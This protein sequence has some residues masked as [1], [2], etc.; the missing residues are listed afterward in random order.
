MFSF[1]CF[2]NY[3]IQQMCDIICLQKKTQST[4]FFCLDP[5]QLIFYLDISFSTLL[6]FIYQYL[7][8]DRKYGYFQISKTNTW[9][10]NCYFNTLTICCLNNISFAVV[11]HW[12]DTRII[13]ASSINKPVCTMNADRYV[14]HIHSNVRPS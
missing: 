3:F 14:P 13:Y 10:W 12:F 5:I 7:V 4:D 11:I 1:N 8:K 6:D 2:W 9:L